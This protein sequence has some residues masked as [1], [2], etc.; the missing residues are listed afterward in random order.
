MNGSNINLS[1]SLKGIGMT[2]TEKLFNYFLPCHVYY[3]FILLFGENIVIVN[4]SIVEFSMQTSIW[5]FP[6]PNKVV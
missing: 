1:N 2:L 4:K 3:V 6:E 5:R